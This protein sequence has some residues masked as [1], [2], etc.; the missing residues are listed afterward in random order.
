MHLLFYFSIF[1]FISQSIDAFPTPIFARQSSNTRNDLQNGDCKAFSLIFARGTTETGNIGVVV[2]PAF[3]SA[4]GKALPGGS[5]A[6]AIQGV[7]YPADVPGFLA[8]GDAAGS[9][10]MADFAAKACSSTAIILAGYS[11]GAQLVHNAVSLMSQAT[12]N[13]VT[14]VVMFGDPDEGDALGK[15]LDA[16]S[17]TFCANGDLICLGQAIVLPPHL[18][19]GSDAG[20]A[21]AFVVSQIK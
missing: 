12:A 1:T 10:D 7:N 18:S 17:K 2:G 3:I 21:A 4:L 5:K 9:Q 14:A 13:K 20:A 16:K 11:Q 8:G 15:G 6:L 19:Y